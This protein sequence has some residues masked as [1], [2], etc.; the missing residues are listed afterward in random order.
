[1][2]NE[3]KNKVTQAAKDDTFYQKTLLEADT[4][5]AREG[6]EPLL[7]ES[8]LVE[9]EEKNRETVSGLRAFLKRKNIEISFQRYAVD[10]LGAMAL[11]LFASLLIGTIVNSLAGLV[12][13]K[14]QKI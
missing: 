4:K 10:A 8:L 11:G 1:M 7:R 9:K 13:I 14:W 3:E 6:D 2:K 12:G 5:P